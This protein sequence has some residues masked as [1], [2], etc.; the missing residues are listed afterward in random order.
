MAGA[1]TGVPDIASQSH[2]G[3][4]RR[5]LLVIT[6]VVLFAAS[7]AGW[8]VFLTGQGLE[9]ADR[10]VSV[11]GFFVN[12]LLTA[13]SLVVAWWALRRPT[14][15]A[16]EPLGTGAVRVGGSS[17]G[18]ISTTVTGTPPPGGGAGSVS[19]GGDSTAAITTRVTTNP[20]PQP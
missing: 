14:R 19:V 5:T 18:R 20:T 10:W 2:D 3:C 8:A 11:V 6:A 13:G 15:P 17:S 7:L 1:W 9:N 12:T 16:D 4:M